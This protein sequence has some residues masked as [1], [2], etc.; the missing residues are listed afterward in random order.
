MGYR[1]SVDVGGTFT[2][3]VLFDEEKR[4]IYT[5]KVSS[6]PQDQ[7]IGLIEGIQKICAQ[8][9]IRYS[10]INY[11]IH[12]TTV[13]TNA[14]LERKGAKAALI[15]TAGFRDVFEIG[16]QR[17]PSLYDFWAKR[18]KPPIPRNLIFEVT[19]RIVADGSE[20]TELDREQ[21][22]NIAEKIR[23]LGI[24]SVAICFLH[25]Y[26]NGSHELEMKEILHGVAPDIAISTSYETLPEIREYERI[27]TTSVNAYLMPKVQTY[28]DHLV[29]K[30]NALGIVPPLHVM[31]SNGGIMSA[32]VAARRSVHTVF[33]GPAGGVL[34]GIAIAKLIGESNVITFDMG[35]TSTDIAL[36]KDGEYRLTTEGEIGN[37]PIK[38]PMIEMH[39]I[40]TGGGS[41]AWI[42][43]GGTL[44]LGPESCGASPGPACYGQGGTRPSVSDANLVLGRL[45]PDSF[46]GG[47]KTIY[48]ELSEKAVMENV[49]NPLGLNAIDSAKGI[50]AIADANMCGGVKVVS[51]QKGF[52]LR[53]FSLISFGGA[54]SLHAAAIAQE[55]NMKR[56]IVP[57]F[58]GN[59]S[60]VGDELA[61]V[62]YD[63]V[64]TIVRNL[65]K[66]TKEEY[67]AAF[68]EM[69]RE[70]YVHMANEGFDSEQMSFIGTADMRYAG[71]A[72]EMT[73][74]IPAELK[75]E[76]DLISIKQA[77][78]DIHRQA[79]GYV[80]EDAVMFINLR[81]AAIAIVPKIEFPRFEMKDSGSDCAR[82]GTRMV[83]FDQQFY[84]TEIYD[85]EFMEPGTDISGPAIIE[86]YAST[87]VVPPEN[88][89][90]IDEYKN[91]II[92][93][94]RR[95][96]A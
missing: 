15:T 82:K 64:R 8:Y 59:F 35:G 80:L 11:F 47:E 73:V 81:L 93:R 61:E 14:L 52:D 56:V 95:E 18:P 71:Q 57:R 92:E 62:R 29:E 46:L 66:L 31:Q 7:S 26:K 49:G 5:T 6:T 76:E 83:F 78:E 50:L 2:D 45:H 32:E 21:A 25:S 39:T 75:S 90:W 24:E 63:Y 87:I 42:D 60:A 20:R 68:D 10:D 37:F 9:G 55:L 65:E 94:V 34:G 70:A 89:A 53:E 44:R 27:C 74:P 36:I 88:H 40:G 72:W 48:P 28:I 85:R 38:V 96:E 30:K 69:K 67:N 1:L 17:R 86:E 23:D 41:L 19:E 84:E 16:R 91:V 43:G 33:S 13:A 54:G 3:I 4:Q 22:K 79:Y 77:F 51:T 12:G 58:P